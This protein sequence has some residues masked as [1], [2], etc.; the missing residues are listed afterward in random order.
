ML[1]WL[2]RSCDRL[3][4]ASVGLIQ[5][6][7]MKH[8]DDVIVFGCFKSDRVITRRTIHRVFPHMTEAEVCSPSKIE[9]YLASARTNNC[10]LTNS[11]MEKNVTFKL[12]VEGSRQMRTFRRIACWWPSAEYRSK[13]QHR[14]AC[15]VLI[16]KKYFWNN[17]Q[18]LTNTVVLSW[19]V[20]CRLCT[21]A[22]RL[23][24]RKK[25]SMW[26]PM[27]NNDPPVEI[28]L[29]SQQSLW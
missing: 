5:V 23:Q 25:I 4:D 3:I 1:S 19:S 12:R 9:P 6:T 15:S 28:N 8:A 10:Y 24:C 2:G 7:R 21:F 16:E 27:C 13:N 18:T 29:L 14:C 22:I 17:L 11:W 20:L 26:L